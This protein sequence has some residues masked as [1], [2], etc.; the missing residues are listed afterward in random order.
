MLNQQKNKKIVF[1][2]NSIRLTI[3]LINIAQKQTL[4]DVCLNNGIYIPHFCYNKYL[5]IAGNC[6][7]CLVEVAK[8]LKPIISCL[9][10]V[11]ENLNIFTT[12][13]SI[14]KYRENVLEF[15]LLNHPLDCPI[16]DQ[17]GECDLQEQSLYFGFDKS[18]NYKKK[19]TNSDLFLNNYIKVILNRCILCIRCVRFIT[20]YNIDNHI[21]LLGTIGRGSFSK[22]HLYI[23]KHLNLT[24]N[25]NIIDICPVG[26]LTSKINQFSFRPW[27]IQ[28]I[29]SFN[30]LDC[31]SSPIRIELK[32]FKIIRILPE[33]DNIFYLNF[34][35]DVVR[36]KTK[37]HYFNI[38]YL[39]NTSFKFNIPMLKSNSVIVLK[40]LNNCF[41]NYQYY[42]YIF[43][44]MFNKLKLFKSFI[45]YYSN[46]INEYL[47]TKEILND[48]KF[49]IVIINKNNKLYM[50]QFF[51][52]L[53]NIN[54]NLHN[55]F[56]LN[57]KDFNL[58]NVF[59]IYKK[60]TS[61]S[62]NTNK[63]NNLNINF[64]IYLIKYLSFLKIL[65]TFDDLFL[66]K[67]IN[68]NFYINSKFIT[69]LNFSNII[70]SNIIKNLKLVYSIYPE[71]NNNLIYNILGLNIQKFNNL[72]LNNLKILTIFYTYNYNLTNNIK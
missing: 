21:N 27:E 46:F 29:I 24:N 32:N 11:I 42:N 18:R 19:K 39:E 10:L 20:E 34:F 7:I 36:I 26:A 5:Q 57:T 3:N 22:I 45:N 72:V 61:I 52:Y 4:L 60:K 47:M 68:I 53:N 25:I 59:S 63:I 54:K 37:F 41:F 65:L 28:S 35:N 62:F 67:L 49:L 16:C 14:K 6:R 30:Y 70:F 31:F 9:N 43:K 17:A 56:Y 48:L 55:I 50:Y 1:K 8:L 44:N 13:F 23:N 40:L 33:L 69:Y 71:Y 64:N 38:N 15:L 51:L 66:Y 58:K 12:S 2:L